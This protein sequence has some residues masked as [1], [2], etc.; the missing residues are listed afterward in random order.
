MLALSIIQ[1]QTA[2]IAQTTFYINGIEDNRSFLTFYITNVNVY[3]SGK[4]LKNRQVAIKD[5]K[6]EAI[7]EKLQIPEGAKVLQAQGAYL[8]PAFIDLYSD[9]GIEKA[10]NIKPEKKETDDET[11][12]GW[13]KAIKSYQHAAN[14]LKKNESKLTAYQKAGFGYTVSHVYDGIARGTG[15]LV[16]LNNQ[17]NVESVIESKSASFYSFKK[18][19][20]TDTYPSSLTGAIALLRQTFEDAKWYNSAKGKTNYTNLN[21][22]AWNENLKLPRVFECSDKNDIYRADKIAKEFGT[23]FIFKTSGN[24]YREIEAVKK[25]GA[26][27][28][29]PIFPAKSFYINSFE[30]AMQIPLHELM[31]WEHANFNVKAI[32]DAGI[33]FAITADGSDLNQFFNRLAVIYQTGVSTKQ[34]VD[35]L[36]LTPA[37]MLGKENQLGKIE[38]GYPASF[39]ISQDSLFGNSF[40]ISASCVNGIWTRFKPEVQLK[41]GNYVFYIVPDTIRVEVDHEKVLKISDPKKKY[42]FKVTEDFNVLQVI[43]SKK[44]SIVY[45]LRGVIL[46][47]TLASGR[48][49]DILRE[50]HSW[51][52]M[53][54][55]NNQ[56][57]VSDSNVSKIERP[58]S[59]IL[60]PFNAWGYEKIPE[61]KVYLIKNITVWTSE[62][63]GILYENDV[64]LEGGKIK[65]VGKNLSVSGAVVIDGFGKHLTAGIIDEHSHI[66]LTNGVNEYGKATSAEVRMA[67]VIDENDIDMYR[68]L[69]GGV[70]TAQLLH[71]SANPIGGQSAIIKFRWGNSAD[72]LLIK[73][74]PGFIKF[75]LG[76]NPRQA[77]GFGSNRYPQTRLGVEQY[78]YD[79][80]SRAQA[81]KQAQKNYASSKD[82]IKIAPRKELYLEAIAEILEQKRFVTCHSYIQSEINML[83]HVADSFNFKINTFTHVLE[84][85]KVASKLAKHG[86]GAS[87]FSDWWAYKY[88]VNDAIPFNAFILNDKNVN[89]AINS[90]D[91]EMGRRLNQE[92]A[93]AM[94]YGGMSETDALNMVTINPAKMLHI[95]AL[96]GSIKEGKQADVV[97]WNNHPLSIYA[98]VDYTFV[99][100]KLLYEASKQTEIKKERDQLKIKL[101]EKMM[102]SG[103]SNSEMRS[104]PKGIKQHYHCDTEINYE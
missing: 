86:A 93:K 39:F 78:Y 20:S 102:R 54:L 24:E 3:Q 35:A 19:S 85:Y 37:K 81:Y 98:K 9:Y 49:I 10:E 5:G 79:H 32:V 71:G 29:V 16:A 31:H 18:G 63:E 21:L 58:I 15:C 22:E 69:A 77:N 80:F 84:G 104:A 44:D 28:I 67:D 41:N 1:V 43:V 94:K 91:A 17:K 70:T 25:M 7:G 89:T 11:L 33:P 95:D 45:S 12:L 64:W 103:K 74:A 2:I 101:I 47:D 75:A 59:P 99:E 8:Y 36:T 38:V 55:P 26:N 100:G 13:N 52:L 23:S 42:N 27:L 53:Y 30:E 76:E 66:C 57:A 34:I 50:S 56:V 14:L 51:K 60:Y 48:G 62:K 40:K 90:D 72:N 46:A 92:A 4:I 65:K 61:Q 83:M 96:T 73:E 87:T 68:Q 88:E 82:K 97:I 6:I